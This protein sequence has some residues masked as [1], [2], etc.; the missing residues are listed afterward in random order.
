MVSFSTGT[1]VQG[2][3]PPAIRAQRFLIVK[4]LGHDGVVLRGTL[5]TVSTL[6]CFRKAM[7]PYLIC[8]ES[9]G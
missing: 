1:A 6:P 9:L 2:T 7:S 5:H 8:G 3:E 4:L